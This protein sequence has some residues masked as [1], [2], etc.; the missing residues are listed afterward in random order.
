MDYEEL[1]AVQIPGLTSQETRGCLYCG[2]CLRP[3]PATRGRWEGA[4]WGDG[5]GGPFLLGTVICIPLSF[6]AKGVAFE[7]SKTELLSSWVF[8]SP[9]AVPDLHDTV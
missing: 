5:G 7:Y 3:M 8:Y 1:Q 4:G 9:G 6:T 2:G